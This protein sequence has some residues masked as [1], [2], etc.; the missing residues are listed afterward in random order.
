MTPHAYLVQRRVRLA[1]ELLRVGRT[2]AEAT[3]EAG[4][5]DQ[6]HVTRTFARCYGVTPA[7]Y[8]ATIAA[9]C[10]A[11]NRCNFGQDLRGSFRNTRLDQERP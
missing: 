2:P 10:Q 7:R 6:S 5:S 1:R 8:R 4:F 3:A 9:A 11:Q